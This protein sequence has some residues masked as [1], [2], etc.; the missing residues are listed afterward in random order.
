MGYPGKGERSDDEHRVV[1]FILDLSDPILRM[2]L[3]AGEGVN[4]AAR[5]EEKEALKN[6]WVVRWKMPAANAPPQAQNM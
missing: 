4:Y 5:G 1:I 2:F 6:A 3:L